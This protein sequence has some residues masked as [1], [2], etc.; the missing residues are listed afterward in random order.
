MA[1]GRCLRTRLVPTDIFGWRVEVRKRWFAPDE[2]KL[3]LQRL[4]R[5]EQST[6]FDLDYWR[7]ANEEDMRDF[8]SI[9]PVPRFEIILPSRP[10]A[11][12]PPP[13]KPSASERK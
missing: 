1:N 12:A 9:F 7:D 5:S 2:R 11:P 6:G 4:L 10:P 3:I 8:Q 13:P